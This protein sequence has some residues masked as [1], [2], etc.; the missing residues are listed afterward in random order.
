MTKQTSQALF[1]EREIDFF[2]RIIF[3][4]LEEDGCLRRIRRNIK[5][6]ISSVT[7]ETI[8]LALEVYEE[9]DTLIDFLIS[10]DKSPEELI[11]EKEIV[12]KVSKLLLFCEQ[13]FI[14]EKRSIDIIK[15]RY[16]ISEDKKPKTLEEIGQSFGL[17][18]ERVRQIDT[19]TIRKLKAVFRANNFCAK[20]FL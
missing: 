19:L 15:M 2:T 13:H 20:N 16:G 8:S 18:R 12:E 3:L 5:L 6:F 11:L 1:S 10:E 9:G 4:N 17:T 7:Q 14:L